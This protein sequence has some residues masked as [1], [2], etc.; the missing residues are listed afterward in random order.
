MFHKRDIWP[1]VC[2]IFGR[3]GLLCSI[4]GMYCWSVCSINGIYMEDMDNC[5]SHKWYVKAAL[6]N[7]GYY[8]P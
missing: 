6:V 7:T 5:M 1:D 8:V 4:I 2:S 3:Y